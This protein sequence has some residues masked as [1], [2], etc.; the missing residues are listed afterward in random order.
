MLSV[1]NILINVGILTLESLAI[2][3]YLNHGGKCENMLFFQFF[4][5]MVLILNWFLTRYDP[6]FLQG[7]K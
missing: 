1:V 3:P 4:K 7:E 5:I 2:F 6:V